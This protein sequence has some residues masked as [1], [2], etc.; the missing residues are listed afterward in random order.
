V[1]ICGL[2]AV[3]RITDEQQV[4]ALRHLDVIIAAAKESGK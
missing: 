3:G 4:E 2:N 1:Y